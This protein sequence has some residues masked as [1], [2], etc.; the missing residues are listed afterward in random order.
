MISVIICCHKC[1]L[2]LQTLV[3]NISLQKPGEIIVV[4][5]EAP[6]F[7]APL[8]RFVQNKGVGLSAARNTGIDESTGQYIVFIDDDAIPDPGWLEYIK[9]EFAMGADITGGT[10]LPYYEDKCNLPPSLNWLV[11]CTVIPNPIGCNFAMRRDLDLRFNET[12]GKIN[13]QGGIGEETDLINRAIGK[14]ITF[15]PHALVWHRVPPNR[16]KLIYLLKRAYNEGKY[17]ARLGRTSREYN[18]ALTY[19]KSL[20]PLCWSILATTLLGYGIEKCI[21]LW[22]GSS[23]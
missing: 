13:G 6:R 7:F 3:H 4:T 15:N 11:G 20:N 16:L 19:I 2:S 5:D 8:A 21:S 17:K 14:R 9:S 1:T 18:Q 22:R 12:L 23:P 10:V